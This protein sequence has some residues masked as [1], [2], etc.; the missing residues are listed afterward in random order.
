MDA[1]Q[2]VARRYAE[3]LGGM[4]KVAQVPEGS[5]SA[6]AQFAIETQGRDMLKAFLQERGI[7][8]VVYYPK[9]LHL[10]PA[11]RHFPRTPDG[12]PVSEGLPERILCLPM[13]PYLEAAD[14]DL[15]IEAIGEF[16]QRKEARL[17]AE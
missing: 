3:K 7:P 6:W 1:R 16:H 9:P 15:V 5:R 17:A 8:S 14:Q 12:L 4:V 13:H 2:A 10:Q 11:Y